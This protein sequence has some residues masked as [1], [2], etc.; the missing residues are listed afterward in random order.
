MSYSKLMSSKNPGLILILIDQSGSMADQYSGGTKA[1]VAAMAVNRVINEIA[2]ASQSGEE[3][4]DRCYV[5]VMG[6]GLKS[7]NGIDPIIGGMIAKIVK[8]P[9]EVIEV[10]QQVADGNGGLVIIKQRMPIWIKPKAENGTPMA[11]AFEKAYQLVE[12]WVQKNPASFPPVIVNIT[13]GKPNDQNAAQNAAKK[14]ME[15][16]ETTDGKLL[17]FNAHISNATAGE[18][19]LANNDSGLYDSYAKFL[20]KIS[21]I[22]P[23]R[24]LSEAEKAGFAPQP[25]ARGFV[26]NAGAETLIKL[27]TFGT[28]GSMGAN[29]YLH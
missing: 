29:K 23:D 18:I 21:S 3:Y 19:R 5:G 25:N 12:S 11:E 10:E 7:N 24:L 1:E 14:L 13:D 26:F 2:E 17:L 8:S 20:F 16:I 15:E 28:V 9:A 4:K 27:L 6:Y 22:L